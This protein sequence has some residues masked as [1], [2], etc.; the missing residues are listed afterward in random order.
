VS[1]RASAVRGSSAQLNTSCST[2]D[3]G[4][5]KSMLH[6]SLMYIISISLHPVLK[7]CN[8]AVPLPYYA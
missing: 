6:S 1:E 5:S 3:A 2:A 8:G 7:V 4:E